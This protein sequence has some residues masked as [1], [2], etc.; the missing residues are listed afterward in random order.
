MSSEASWPNEFADFKRLDA[1][2]KCG[3]CYDYMTNSMIT[4]CSHTYCSLCIRKFMQY[5][6]QCPACFEETYEIH[7]R[8][9]RPLDE[10]ITIF[11]KMKEKLQRAL[12]LATIVPC[13]KDSTEESSSLAKTPKN[14]SKV[15]APKTPSALRGSAGALAVQLFKTNEDSSVIDLSGDDLLSSSSASHQA[16][17]CREKKMASG[18]SSAANQSKT[19]GLPP[20]SSQ[21]PSDKST[22]GEDIVVN[23]VKIPGIFNPPVVFPKA[24]KP[25]EMA[26]CPVCHVD[27]PARNI[28]MHLDACLAAESDVCQKKEK[29]PKK[30]PLLPK[31]LYHLMQDKGLKK[32][33]KEYGL[34]T[35][36]DRK[37]LISRIQRY[38]V[39]YNAENDSPNPRSVA[40]LIAQVDRQEREEK[41]PCS[42]VKSLAKQQ[43]Q[44]IVIDRKADPEVIEQAN[45]AYRDD[46]RDSFMKLIEQM[47]A[48]EGK[49]IKP[50][51]LPARVYSD[52]DDDDSGLR[53]AAPNRGDFDPNRPSTSRDG[54]TVDPPLTSEQDT[55]VD[56]NEESCES[57]S[58][59]FESGPQPSGLIDWNK[60]RV[61]EADTQLPAIE[62]NDDGRTDLAKPSVIAAED[63]A[64]ETLE[65]RKTSH[66]SPSAPKLLNH[67]LDP[68]TL[69][70][71]SEEDDCFEIT[72]KTPS[73]TNAVAKPDTPAAEGC[74]RYTPFRRKS[75]SKDVANEPKE[76]D[77]KLAEDCGDDE[78]TPQNARTKRRFTRS[79]TKTLS[80]RG[81]KRK[82]K[83]SPGSNSS[84][85]QD[86]ADHPAG[87][88]NG[89][90]RDGSASPTPTVSTDT[91]ESDELGEKPPQQRT[92]RRSLRYQGDKSAVSETSNEESR[93]ITRKRARKDLSPAF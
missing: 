68:P 42:L 30:R 91:E 4:S 8:N 81:T 19:P 52:D 92:T 40:E 48:R 32:V 75:L 54:S 44:R 15:F 93:R 37:T 18:A 47:R 85:S 55:S 82:S 43:Q 24:K 12:R 9:N 79:T 28:N 63:E 45:K 14:S 1:V 7:L 27:V 71:E 46:N 90:G 50:T 80:A 31:R 35:N 72:S 5:K 69:D 20:V 86:S 51:G 21:T 53:T 39:L 38:T 66:T 36:G 6:N 70:S 58:D 17:P 49:Y 74:T 84:E 61:E 76:Q 73:R 26:Q 59:I 83:S 62:E 64:I 10:V 56:Q 77:D 11:V 33:C 89:T 13:A 57:D 88:C 41:R 78:S 22:T 23:G 29:I 87:V 3:I 34:N 67:I 60:T 2:L 65:V 25:D 16:S